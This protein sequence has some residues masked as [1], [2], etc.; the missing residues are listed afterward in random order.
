LQVFPGLTICHHATSLHLPAGLLQQPFR[1]SPNLL[2]T[3]SWEHFSA[4]RTADINFLKIEQFNNLDVYL[5]I[6]LLICKA[7]ADSAGHCGFV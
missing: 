4:R 3:P 5:V 6:F 2:R 1:Q 7:E